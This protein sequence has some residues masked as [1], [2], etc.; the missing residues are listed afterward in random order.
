VKLAPQK[1]Q[2]I[3]V[4]GD[5]IYHIVAENEWGEH[6]LQIIATPG[7]RLHAFTF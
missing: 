4:K 2:S 7:L 3:D 1:E 5:D 6:S